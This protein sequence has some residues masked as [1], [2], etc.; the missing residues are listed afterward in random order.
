MS[1]ECLVEG[2]EFH[3]FFVFFFVTTSFGGDGDDKDKLELCLDL[4]VD[5][6]DQELFKH[7]FAHLQLEQSLSAA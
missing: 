3:P 5:C 4:L 1:N 2:G 6:L 7:C